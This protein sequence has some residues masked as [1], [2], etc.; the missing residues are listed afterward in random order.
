MEDLQT[1]FHDPL[2]SDVRDGD[3]TD[4]A[5]CESACMILADHAD[6]MP[7]RITYCS[8]EGDVSME[9]WDEQNT[10]VE[11]SC[12]VEVTRGTFC[13]GRRPQGHREADL[14]VDSEGT[15][16]A[17]HA[18]LERA[19]VTA[20]EELAAW[21]ED[22]RAPRSLVE[23]CRSAAADEVVHA[24]LMAALAEEHGES[25]P[26]SE[27]E[28]PREDLL[29][30]AL[31]NAVEGCVHE[32]FAAIVACH[33]AEHAQGEAMRA[34][35]GRIAADELRHAQLAWDLHAWLL[36]HLDEGDRARVEA[37]QRR[38]LRHLPTRM[39]AGARATPS[40]MGWPTPNHALAMAQRFAALV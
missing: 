37:A 29:A 16:L 36:A 26:P 13:T 24:E 31:H 38:A 39:H 7:D 10:A 30:V 3:D 9:P 20:F 19:S 32:A 40:S 6:L 11:V 28:P 18:H 34:T 15:W 8:A 21:L 1:T 4:E 5:R 22:R 12:G 35:F 25:A 33:Q 14:A 2:L 17:V 27:A 23:R